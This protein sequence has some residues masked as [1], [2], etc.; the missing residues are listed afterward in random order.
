MNSDGWRLS[1]IRKVVDHWPPSNIEKHTFTMTT[2]IKKMF[3]FAI[4]LLFFC[5]FFQSNFQNSIFI[6]NSTQ[7]IL[8]NGPA[9]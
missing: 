5:F 1:V 4:L 7:L 8:E 3:S 6:S 2:Q 9:T